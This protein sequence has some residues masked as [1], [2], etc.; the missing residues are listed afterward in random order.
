MLKKTDI[1]CFSGTGNTWLVA[2]E[3]GEELR[4]QGGDVQLFQLENAEPVVSVPERC[5]GLAFPV[6]AQ[7]TYPLVWNFVNNLPQG[8]GRGVFMVDTLASY[9]GGVVVPL[10]R[11]LVEKGYVPLGAREVVMPNNFLRRRAFG[12]HDEEVIARGL[13]E[14]RGFA[15]ALWDG[16]TIWPE[17]ERLA[18]VMHAINRACFRSRLAMRILRPK[19]KQEQCTG[20]GVCAGAC[21]VGNIR[22]VE[23]KARIGGMCQFC[24]R[25]RGVCPAGAL[26]LYG[27][28]PYYAPTPKSW[29]QVV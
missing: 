11:A 7:S 28:H 1:Y 24:M 10:R 16:S 5:L 20:C 21:P 3:I 12:Q 23:G 27:S 4:R 15:R 6:A 26:G 9:S 25:C 29:I 18:G 19:V 22:V 8:R 14:A 13:E 2:R 17:R